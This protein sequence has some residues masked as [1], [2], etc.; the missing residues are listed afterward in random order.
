MRK[1]RVGL[2]M[3]ILICFSVGTV[4]WAGQPLDTIQTPIEK[5]LEIL[6]KPKTEDQA[7]NES[8]R[9][10][11]WKL[12]RGVFDFDGMAKLALGKHRRSF[13][14]SLMENYIKE[15]TDLVGTNYFDRMQSEYK[16]EKVQ[17]L[18]EEMIS[19]NKALVKTVIKRSAGDIK[20]DYK[21]RL[22]DKSWV[23][24][25]VVIEE[26]SLIQNY[27]NEIDRILFKEKPEKLIEI[28]REKIEQNKAQEKKD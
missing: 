24:Y 19:S 17:F 26:K 3:I 16:D 25:D 14:D 22:R 28:L 15:F 10:D 6:K 7:E 9:K 11:M 8:R 1:S 18:G 2:I 20:V 27:R 21:L 13:P 12:I 4:A 23:V 5:M